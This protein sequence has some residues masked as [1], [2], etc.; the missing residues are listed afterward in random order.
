VVV[1]VVVILRQLQIEE[2]RVVRVVE[3]RFVF[4]LGKIKY[5]GG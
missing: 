1:E 5:Y 4:I 2:A 3:E